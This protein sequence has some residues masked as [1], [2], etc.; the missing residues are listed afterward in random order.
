MADEQSSAIMWAA[1]FSESDNVTTRLRNA[2]VCN[3]CDP[4]AL[5]QAVRTATYDQ[6]AKDIIRFAYKNYVDSQ[7][8]GASKPPLE[9]FI[10][11]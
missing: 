11:P 5:L 7:N 3:N 9:M 1:G 8:V 2:A 10:I 6:A 4:D